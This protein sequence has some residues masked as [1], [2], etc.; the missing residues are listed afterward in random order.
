MY[1]MTKLIDVQQIIP[2]PEAQEY[3]IQLRE[4]EQLERKQQSQKGE[5]RF[6]FFQG[7]IDI[8]R[9]QETRHANIKAGVNHWIGASSGIRGLGLN[10]V[11]IQEY[12]NVELYI[13][14]GEQEENKRIFDTLAARKDGIDKAFGSALSWERL[15]SK[16]ACRIKYVLPTG[17]FLSPESDWPKI[18]EALVDA[19]SRLENALKPALDSLKL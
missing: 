9:A 4:K 19:M 12:C 5:R 11:A 18:Q 15:D 2:L 6:R 16:R 17:S 10:Y 14:R 7:I 13:D 3:Q 1:G 8:A